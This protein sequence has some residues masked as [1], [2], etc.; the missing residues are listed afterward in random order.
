MNCPSDEKLLVFFS[1]DSVPEEKE[2]EII[3]LHIAGCTTCK[4]KRKGIAEKLFTSANTIS[5]VA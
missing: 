5:L 2:K 1:F 3:A 4:A